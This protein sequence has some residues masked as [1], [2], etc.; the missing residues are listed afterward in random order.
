M[1]GILGFHQVCKPKN[2]KNLNFASSLIKLLCL[3][4]SSLHCYL[5]LF[6]FMFDM[7]GFVRYFCIESMQWFSTKVGD[8]K[9]KHERENRFWI[10]LALSLSCWT[11]FDRCSSIGFRSAD[12]GQF[13]VK[14]RSS[15]SKRTL[16]RSAC[17]KTKKDKESRSCGF[18]EN[19]IGKL[20][21]TSIRWIS[22]D[23]KQR[24]NALIEREVNPC[25]FVVLHTFT[26]R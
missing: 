17:K 22:V 24:N 7:M 20:S 16:I 2:L 10:S 1:H 9:V 5:H 18:P 19:L 3:T 12:D 4:W 11:C 15:P 23:R 6:H 25:F 13:W 26:F 21:E 14:P 8:I